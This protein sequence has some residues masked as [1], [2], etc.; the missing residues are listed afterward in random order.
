M[1]FKVLLY[2]WFCEIDDP[3]TFAHEHRALCERLN[4]H[5]RILVAEEGINGSVSGSPSAC[6]AYQQALLADPRFAE[7]EFKVEECEG[8]TFKG[9]YV[10]VRAE[11]ITLGLPLANPVHEVTGQHLSPAEWLS[12][13][14]EDDVVLLDGRNDYESTVGRFKGALCP[15]VENFREFPA[16]LEAHREE[17]KGK[18][19][20]TYCTGGIRCEKL[21]SWMLANGFE[22]VYQLHGGIVSY[23]QNPETEGEGFEGVN[24]VFDDRVVTSAG[25]RSTP[26]TKCRECGELC[27][28]Y[29]NCA[30][31][32]CNDRMIMCP[33]CEVATERCC[34]SACRSSDSRREKGQKLR[35]GS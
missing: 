18:Q 11:I 13:M 10:R 12:K 26:L 33:S 15:P 20:L 8:H 23:A 25:P 28:N 14:S 29:V 17:L 30:N 2:Y 22:N 19:I 1:A 31:V 32:L 3:V 35:A 4:L 5:G 16:W 24:V 21:S 27:A 34:S 7:M 9:M 6:D